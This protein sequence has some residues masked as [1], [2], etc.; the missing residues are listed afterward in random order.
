MFGEIQPFY[1]L[2][3]GGRVREMLAAISGEDERIGGSNA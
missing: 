3:P 2:D 1:S